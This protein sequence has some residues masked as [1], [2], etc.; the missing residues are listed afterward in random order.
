MC[1]VFGH[2]SWLYA[3]L[4]EEMRG[5]PHIPDPVTFRVHVESK[6]IL[7]MLLIGIEEEEEFNKEVQHKGC[8]WLLS[9][10]STG[11]LVIVQGRPQVRRSLS[12]NLMDGHLSE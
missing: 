9:L 5:N 11:D 7:C 12:E 1:L 2:Y 6:E 4:R 3:L 8:P 10:S